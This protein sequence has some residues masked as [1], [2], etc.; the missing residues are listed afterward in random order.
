MQRDSNQWKLEEHVQGDYKCDECGENFQ[1]PLLTTISSDSHSQM[2]YACPRCL[3]RVNLPQ[4]HKSEENA[5]PTKELGISKP[6]IEK[7]AGCQHFFGFLGKRQKDTPIPD[8]CLTCSKMV[9]C[10]VR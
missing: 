5:A 1:N 8:D 10:L 6:S 3:T 4:A 7:A 9:E 2:Y